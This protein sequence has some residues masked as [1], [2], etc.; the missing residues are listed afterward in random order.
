[1]KTSHFRMPTGPNGSKSLFHR[2]ICAG[3]LLTVAILLASVSAGADDKNIS[4]GTEVDAQKIL[5]TARQLV[6][7]TATRLAEFKGEVRV[8]QGATVIDADSLK[9]HYTGGPQ[10][11]T[12]ASTE[13]ESIEKIIAEGRV[14][15][16]MDNRIAFADH[17]VYTTADSVLVLTGKNSRLTSGNNSITGSKITFFRADGRVTV[18]GSEDRRVEAVLFPGDKGLDIGLPQGQ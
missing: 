5:I 6:T 18:E 13:G 3:A 17:A 14:K 1:V 12:T 7:H 4:S 15:I 16:Q 10:D 9:I 2:T 11:K 8:R